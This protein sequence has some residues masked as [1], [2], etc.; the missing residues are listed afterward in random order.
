MEAWD[1][2]ASPLARNSEARARGWSTVIWRERM[3]TT[4]GCGAVL[5]GGLLRSASWTGG[6]ST[7]M[8]SEIL[9]GLCKSNS[10]SQLLEMVVGRQCSSNLGTRPSVLTPFSER[11]VYSQPGHFFGAAR[12]RRYERGGPKTLN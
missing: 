12:R 1:L 4:V 2:D 9:S 6:M 7:S 10:H 5:S 11:R 3:Y 8:R